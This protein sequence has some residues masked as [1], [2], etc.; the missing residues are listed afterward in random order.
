[1]ST[2]DQRNAAERRAADLKVAVTAAR[3]R[4]FRAIANAFELTWPPQSL[5]YHY[6]GELMCRQITVMAISFDFN[7]WFVGILFPGRLI[8]RLSYS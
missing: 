1:M 3:G 7:S 2:V 6:D 4:P 8:C 5:V